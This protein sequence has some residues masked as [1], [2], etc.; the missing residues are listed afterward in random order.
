MQKERIESESK[1]IAEYFDKYWTNYTD[2]KFDNTF[3]LRNWTTIMATIVL[4][5]NKNKLKKIFKNKKILHIG[6]GY[7]YFL[8]VVK[9]LYGIPYGI[10]P[11][12]SFPSNL[13]IIKAKVEDLQNNDSG[14]S[15]EFNH[16][17]FDVIFAH[18]VFVP[19]IIK[20]NA[21][22]IINSLKKYL[23]KDGLMVF[24]SQNEES[25]LK[26]DNIKKYGLKVKIIDNILNPYGKTCDQIIIKI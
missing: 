4:H 16:K 12:L 19:S 18:D 20:D 9:N 25:S 21:N 22:I 2:P 23:R 17:K 6:C 11:Y 14:L 10:E 13:N 5:Y 8:E 1:T 24:E 3:S 7:G 15:N 26:I